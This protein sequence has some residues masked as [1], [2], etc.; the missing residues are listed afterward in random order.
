MKFSTE[1]DT[2]TKVAKFFIDDVETDYDNFSIM[3]FRDLNGMPNGV[4]VCYSKR[5]ENNGYE[6]HD[7][8][9]DAVTG[10]VIHYEGRTGSM[11]KS[12]Q[13]LIEKQKQ[14]D[15]L[16]KIFQPT[17]IKQSKTNEIMPNPTELAN[18]ISPTDLSRY[19]P[20]FKS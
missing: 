6:E 19:L 12:F 13:D 14:S 20:H 11:L 10:D 8:T 17:L 15:K 2:E 4:K 16:S 3:R 9:H 5:L 18:R 7:I 1:F